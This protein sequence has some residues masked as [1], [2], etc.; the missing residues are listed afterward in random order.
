MPPTTESTKDKLATWRR[1]TSPFAIDVRALALLRIALGLILFADLALRSTELGSMYADGA[2]YPLERA[3]DLVRV[4][5]SLHLLSGAAWFQATLLGVGML[6]AGLLVIGYRT[7]LVTLLSWYLL[8]SLHHRSYYIQ[9]VGDQLLR[10]LL[11]WCVF[12]PLGRRYS[13]DARF[14]AGTGDPLPGTV[15]SIA[16]AGLLCQFAT[17]YFFGALHKFNGATWRDGSALGMVL[18][19][20]VWIRPLGKLLA[21]APALTRL[22]THTTVWAELLLPLLLISPVATRLCRRVAIPLLAVFAVGIGSCMRLGIIPWLMTAGLIPFLSGALWDRLDRWLEARRPI[23]GPGEQRSAATALVDGAGP[24]PLRGRMAQRVLSTL[25]PGILFVQLFTANVDSLSF[26]GRVPAAIRKAEFYLGLDQAWAMYAPDP[27]V[28]SFRLNIR[29]DLEQGD[30]V[31]L[32]FGGQRPGWPD[33]GSFPPFEDLWYS[34]RGRTL[35][36]YIVFPET[37]RDLHPFLVWACRQW[38]R[39]HPDRP[40]RSA[41]LSKEVRAVR[42]VGRA[43]GELHDVLS[44]EPLVGHICT[45]HD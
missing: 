45:D 16:S 24:V 34:Y 15:R 20:D 18:Q 43:P 21:Q 30:P 29:L 36:D 23:A 40:V 5:I 44:T 17:V 25:L 9:D 37:A 31:L 27:V 13:M 35:L 28:S 22:M 12:L 3:R 39:V 38:T 4:P 33:A 7:R 32:G 2:A 41:G 8:I 42:H 11:L 10:L 26:P 6:L 1:V 19:D 14:R